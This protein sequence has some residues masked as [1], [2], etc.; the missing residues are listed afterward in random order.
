LGLGFVLLAMPDALEGPRLLDVGRGHALSA[1]D[2]VGLV[3]LL[4]GFAD[5]VGGLWHRRA[6]LEARA[7]ARPYRAALTLFAAGLGSGLLLAS[8]LSYIFWWWA[9]GALLLLA[10]LGMALAA[11][12]R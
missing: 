1:L 11:A 10:A 5:L 7:R 3:P 8:G 12:V 4:S 2:A 6:T 9:V